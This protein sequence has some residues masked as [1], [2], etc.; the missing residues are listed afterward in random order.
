MNIQRLHRKNIFF[1]T[2]FL[3]FGAILVWRA[4][5]L[6]LAPRFWAEEGH[7]YFKYAWEHSFLQTLFFIYWKAGYFYLSIN[8]AS[9][10]AAH[11]LPLE[12]APFATAYTAL[13]IQLVPFVIVL[14]G[15]ST[16][17]TSTARKITA[18]LCFLFLPSI[19]HHAW[20]NVLNSQIWFGLIALLIL[21]ED[22][23]GASSRRF[24]TYRFLLAA[25]AL[26]GVY[27][28]FL[29]PV[30]ALKALVERHKERYVHLVILAA[31]LVLQV[32]LVV[33]ASS[34]G[35][36]KETEVLNVGA[37]MLRDFSLHHIGVTLL[38]YDL[39]WKISSTLG[40]IGGYFFLILFLVTL[41]ITVI[42][43][44]KGY[45]NLKDNRVILAVILMVLLVAVSLTAYRNRN[46]DAPYAPRYTVL[47]GFV[48]LFLILDNIRASRPVISCVLA[49]L[50]ATSL[51]TGARQYRLNPAFK[52]DGAYW[53]E[54]VAHWRKDPSHVIRIP[55]L[56]I[57]GLRITPRGLQEDTIPQARLAQM[58]DQVSVHYRLYRGSYREGELMCSSLR[59][60]PL[61]F[62]LGRGKIIP[63]FENAIIGMSENETKIVSL[64]PE[65]AFGERRQDMITAVDRSQIPAHIDPQVGMMMRFSADEWRIT[66]TIM[67][68]ITAD[69]PVTI[70][71]VAPDTITL[72]YNHPL[73][74]HE[75]ALWIE[76]V[77]IRI[78]S[79]E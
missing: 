37:Y 10:I 15:K 31:A 19:T 78:L 48:I 68:D 40:W 77:E 8:I 4:P 13:L 66:G 12:Y 1:L 6:L 33:I 79:G 73:A 3:I 52:M 44:A 54:A 2:L 61:K 56:S 22:L 45:F 38:G 63:G 50:L 18:C 35:R 11:L 14:F 59:R 75:V 64:S 74:G 24:W 53:K 25:C 26:S 29:V 7:V 62:T 65:E 42:N 28:I 17:F 55:P 43:K 58:G 20:L 30:F 47:T 49:L 34:T 51:I 71:D 27:A 41:P 9:A 60:E 46:I 5:R 32:T 69:A 21:L 76:L 36:L 16:L 57:W 39:A 72:D 67:T 23:K 70:V